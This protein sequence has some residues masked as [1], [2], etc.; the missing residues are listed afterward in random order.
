[1]SQ[2][3]HPR[4]IDPLATIAACLLCS[5]RYRISATRRNGVVCHEPTFVAFDHLVGAQPDRGEVVG[6]DWREAPQ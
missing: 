4:R 2:M 1:M 5:D 3:G 6:A